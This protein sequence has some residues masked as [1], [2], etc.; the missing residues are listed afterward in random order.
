[1][2]TAC[3]EKSPPQK[4][5]Q[6]TEFHFGNFQGD[7]VV[8]GKDNRLDLYQ[9]SS[10]EV[11]ALA[12]STVALLQASE[13]EDGATDV[14]TVKAVSLKDSQGVCDTEPYHDQPTAAFCSGSLIAPD[15]VLTAGH[16]ITDDQDCAATKFAFGFAVK[17]EGKYPQTIAKADVYGCKEVIHT[18]HIMDGADFAIVRLDRVVTN[19]T[20][21]TL[22]QNGTPAVGDDLTLIG[23]PSGL[24]TKVADGAKVRRIENGFLVANTDSYAGNSGSAVF[25]SHTGEI[26]GVLVRGEQDF[27][28]QN[29]CMVSK[30]CTDDGCRGEDVTLAKDILP[31]VP[32]ASAPQAPDNPATPPPAQQDQ[33]EFKAEPHSSIPDNSLKGVVSYIDATEAPNGREV[34]VKLNITHTWIGDLTVVL[35][36]PDGTNVVLHGREGGS[37]HNLVGTYGVDLESRDPIAALR[38]QS[39]VGRWKLH[40]FDSAPMDR[41]TLESWSLVF[42][43]APA[44]QL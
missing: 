31:F 24:P 6:K 29:G 5:G 18:Q 26:E 40:V 9:I 23:H 27:E 39:Q 37:Q 13:I 12:D 22:R 8:Y 36:A 20:P 28:Y 33:V 34:Q 32:G 11:L 3:G 30:I 17:T 25:N 10:P 21:L 38:N 14:A 44:A 1:M 19:H 41:G 7:Q 2:L 15:L 43:S 16:C 4:V 42:K 35:V